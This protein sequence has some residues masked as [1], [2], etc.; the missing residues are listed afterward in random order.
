MG[1][2]LDI[3]VPNAIEIDGS[4]HIRRHQ[5]SS[6]TDGDTSLSSPSLSGSSIVVDTT[7]PVVSGVYGVNGNGNR[8][9]T[10]EDAA[11]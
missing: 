9:R 6:I 3:G 1:L 2:G 10:R 8:T 11:G 5:S 4:S 7:Q